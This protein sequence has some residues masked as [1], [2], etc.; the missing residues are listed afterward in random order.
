[1]SQLSDIDISDISE[2]TSVT[3]AE[4]PLA[5]FCSP[6]RC[7]MT[8]SHQ[9]PAVSLYWNGILCDVL[10]PDFRRMRYLVVKQFAY[11]GAHD[12]SHGM[13]S[14]SVPTSKDKRHTLAPLEQLAT[15]TDRFLY[16][17][18][19]RL[20]PLS[21]YKRFRYR[22]GIQEEQITVNHEKAQKPNEFVRDHE[23]MGCSVGFYR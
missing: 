8:L 22:L 3:F 20:G 2:N 18:V 17:P 6:K 15:V 12:V 21:P 7:C 16:A 14:N 13:H 9:R 19:D 4:F 23:K 1:M 11:C 5:L 10:H